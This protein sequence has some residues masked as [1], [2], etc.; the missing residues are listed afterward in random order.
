VVK[1][2]GKQEGVSSIL[3][4]AWNFVVNLSN[5]LTTIIVPISV[6]QGQRDASYFESIGLSVSP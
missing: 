2:L 5:H 4:E 1:T 6:M 3:A